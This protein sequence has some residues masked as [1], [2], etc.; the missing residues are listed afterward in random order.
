MADYPILFSGFRH[1]V[2]GPSFEAVITANGRTLISEEDGE[3]WCSGVEPG[4]IIVEGEGPSGAFEK[5]GAAFRH[6][7]EDIAEGAKTFA[8]FETE[9]CALFNTD[10][11]DARRWEAALGHFQKGAEIPEQFRNLP[12]KVWNESDIEVEVRP[13]EKLEKAPMEAAVREER[14]LPLAA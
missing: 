13:L 5:F 7:L 10:P 9:V 6:A 8:V 4:G 1:V 14:S 3:W 11:N 2:K 12:R